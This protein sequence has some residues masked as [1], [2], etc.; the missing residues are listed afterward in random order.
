MVVVGRRGGLDPVGRK[1]PALGMGKLVL[2]WH[3][4]H[5]GAADGVLVGHLLRH[6]PKWAMTSQP[7]PQAVDNSIL[8]TYWPTLRFRIVQRRFD[9]AKMA[10]WPLVAADAFRRRS[11]CFRSVLVAAYSASAASP[12][13]GRGGRLRRAVYPASSASGS[14]R[15]SPTRCALAWSIDGWTTTLWCSYRARP[16]AGPG[17]SDPK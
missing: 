10:D 4:R 6:G 15:R 7:I 1:G 16:S 3:G 17:K 12:P 8:K 5:R 14:S 2:H 11:P 9:T 13:A